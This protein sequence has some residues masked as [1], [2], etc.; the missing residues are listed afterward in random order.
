MVSPPDLVGGRKTF[1]AERPWRKAGPLGTSDVDVGQVARAVA[2]DVLPALPS[3]KTAS[4]HTRGTIENWHRLQADRKDM[5]ARSACH[6]DFPA[7]G[8]VWS[9]RLARRHPWMLL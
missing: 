3:A 4:V 8:K 5:Q 2:C 7:C 9:V 1:G 6:F